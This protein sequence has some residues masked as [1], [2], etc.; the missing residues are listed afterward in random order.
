[1][2]LIAM[3]CISRFTRP[4][5]NGVLKLLPRKMPVADA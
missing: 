4:N 2:L 1:M 5:A 3:W